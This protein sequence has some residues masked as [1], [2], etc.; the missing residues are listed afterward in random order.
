MASLLT[1]SK[2]KNPIAGRYIVT[3]KGGTS[4]AAHISSTQSKIASTQS[5]ITHQFGLINGYAGEFSEDDLNDLRA[6]PEIASIEEDATVKTCSVITQS[7]LPP[8]PHLPERVGRILTDF[9]RTDATWALGRITS[10]DKLTGSEK[11][12]TFKYKY[13]SSA[14]HGIDVYVIGMFLSLTI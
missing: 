3:L 4:L 7:V 6:H 13:D 10:Q 8:P 11:D 9:H 5:N 14:G 2:A 1:V 12:F